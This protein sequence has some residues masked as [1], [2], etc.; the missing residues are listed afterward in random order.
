MHKS[1]SDMISG[2]LGNSGQLGE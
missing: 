2:K 1:F